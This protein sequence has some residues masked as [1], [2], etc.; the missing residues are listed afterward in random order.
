MSE[1]LLLL[2]SA[3]SGV[4]VVRPREPSHW[5]RLVAIVCGVLAVVVGGVDVATRISHIEISDRLALTAFAPAAA[6]NDPAVLAALGS[7]PTSPAAPLVPTRLKVPSLNIDAPVESVGQKADGTMG[8]PSTFT[9]VAWYAQG[10][11]PG[12]PGNAVFAGHVNNALTASGVFSHLS[13]IKL[14]A[15]VQVAGKDGRTLNYM[16][17]SIEEYAVA[18]AP[19]EAIFATEGPSQ[20]ILVTCEGAWDEATHS[21]TKRLVVV[22]KR[23]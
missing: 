14:G 20:I 5:W 18:T 4:L 19:A 23:I 22:A 11:K 7:T 12:G 15:A 10:A 6:L 8:T 13:Q 9:S 1:K 16:V 17:S 3:R 2:S 21:F